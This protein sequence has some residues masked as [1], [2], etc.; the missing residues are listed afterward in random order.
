VR[1]LLRNR[2]F[3]GL[4]ICLAALGGFGCKAQT[5]PAALTQDQLN[6]RIETIVRTR[7]SLP[8]D[9]VVHIGPRMKSELPGYQQLPIAFTEGT[10]TS[11]P[12][13]FLISDDGK[14]LARFD[15]FDL[16]KNPRDMVPTSGRPARGPEDAPVVIVSFDDLECPYCSKMHNQL[17]PDAMQRYPGKLRIVYKDFPLTEIHPWAMHAAVDANCLATQNGTAY[18]NFVD[19]V[20]AHD[21]EIYG[22]D[23]K[24]EVATANLDKAA[25]DEGTRQKVNLDTLKACIAKQD[26]APV[27]ASMNEGQALRVEATPTLF[28]NGEKVDGAQPEENLWKVIDRALAASG[29]PAA[30]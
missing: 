5:P 29:A 26:T 11:Q 17:F 19:Y 6:A 8:S 21:A 28:I 2:S 16:T 23:R 22:P 1:T 12:V 3:S 30:K 13:F 7:F 27:Q 9:V 18:W 14:F 15:K 10:Q 20:H 24:T 25:T 4:L